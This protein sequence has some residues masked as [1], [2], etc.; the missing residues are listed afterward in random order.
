MIAIRNPYV[1]YCFDQAILAWGQH[2]EAA[3]D[4]VRTKG[5]SDSQVRGAKENALRECL[6]LERKFASFRRPGSPAPSAEDRPEPPF[7]M[8]K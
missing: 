6:G 5:K 1:A 4:G 2:C 8:E 3:M 7:D